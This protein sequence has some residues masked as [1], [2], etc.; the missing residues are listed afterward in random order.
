MVNPT[1][2]EILSKT[3][4]EDLAS[5][6]G[7]KH[8]FKVAYSSDGSSPKPIQD[9]IVVSFSPEDTSGGGWIE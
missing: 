5:L 6:C 1:M 4:S 8:T 7:S 3:E 9:Y 2:T